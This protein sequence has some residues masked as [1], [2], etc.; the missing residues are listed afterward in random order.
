MSGQRVRLLKAQ[1]DDEGLTNWDETHVRYTMI[2]PI[3]RALGWDTEDPTVCHPEWPYPDGSGRVDYA[4]FSPANISDLA[5]STVP[6]VVIIEA[7][8]YPEDLDNHLQQ[9]DGYAWT[10]PRMTHGRAILT[11]G[12]EWRVYQAGGRKANL[13]TRHLQTVNIV[14][15]DINGVARVLHDQLGRNQRLN[16]SS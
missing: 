4:L 9:L 15:Q 12:I 10:D 7:K 8:G 3:I 6:P 11:N 16:P 1:W 14:E 5:R 13:R 2:D